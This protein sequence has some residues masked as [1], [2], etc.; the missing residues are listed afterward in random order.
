[1]MSESKNTS[2]Q[3]K[4]KTKTKTQPNTEVWVLGSGHSTHRRSTQDTYVQQ[5][6]VRIPLKKNVSPAKGIDL[7]VD[8][9]ASPRKGIDLDVAN[10]PHNFPR[11]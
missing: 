5:V 11:T 3:K 7:D 9:D 2:N 10:I 8:E 6:Q 4:S 1:M